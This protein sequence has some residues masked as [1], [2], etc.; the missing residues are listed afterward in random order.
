MLLGSAEE[1]LIGCYGSFPKKYARRFGWQCPFVF[2][3]TIWRGRNEV[4]FENE[5]VAALGIKNREY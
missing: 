5:E 1:T 2:F 4:V 3:W